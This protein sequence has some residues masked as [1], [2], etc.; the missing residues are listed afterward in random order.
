MDKDL[1]CFYHTSLLNTQYKKEYAKTRIKD[2]EKL[3][4]ILKPY[5]KPKN[6]I[7]ILED[8]MNEYILAHLPE[9][10][11]Y[12]RKMLSKV[13]CVNFTE[14]HKNLMS[15]ITEFNNKIGNSPYVLIIGVTSDQGADLAHINIYKSNF[16]IMLLSYPHLKKPIDIVFNF[17]V[18]IRMYYPLIKDF[19]IMD[20][21]SYSGS[22][23]FHVIE[24]LN[25]ELRFEKNEQSIDFYSLDVVKIPVVKNKM[26]NL[27]MVIP[28]ISSTA[29]DKLSKINIVSDIK[30]IFY[31]EFL[32][33]NYG[34]VLYTNALNTLDHLYKHF[35]T[36]VDFG[37]LTPIIFQHKIA[38]ML[39]T[40]SIVLIN[41][42]VLDNDT[43]RIPFIKECIYSEEN[44]NP[45]L[46]NLENESLQ[47]KVYCPE[48]PYLFFR[49]ILLNKLGNPNEIDK[50]EYIFN[51]IDE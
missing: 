48:P 22:Q 32:I 42:Q 16:W 8:K 24:D 19:L 44:N 45:D 17:K 15:Q 41:G 14:F 18:A 47:K 33:K 36:W 50:K 7:T 1:N 40:I 3:L 10:Q 37:T 5:L 49:N 46:F 9:N 20:D 13:I 23:F 11:G 4:E 31:F 12:I 35:V 38:D 6:T 34:L 51:T 30:M 29:F 28:Y 25:V 21:C 2:F 26:L 39:S 43:I 27:H